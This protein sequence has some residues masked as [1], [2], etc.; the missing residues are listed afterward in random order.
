VVTPLLV[1]DGHHLL[2]RSWWGFSDRRITSRNKMR[3][4]TGV[5]GFL[6]ILRKTHL[7]EAP[8][9]E[10]IVVFDGEN[11]AAI[12]QTRDSGYK[13]NRAGV[14][15]TAIKSLGMIK[16]G[17]DATGVRWIELD[18][19]EGDDIVATIAHTAASAGRNVTC[20]SS[21]R[22]FY[23]LVNEHITLLT[24][25]RRRITPA[26]VSARHHITARQWPD[27]RALT[28]DSCDNIPG[29][30]GIGP[31]TAATL[32]A[33]GIHLEQLRNSSRLD[34]PRCRT[35]TQH[36]GQLLTW[37]D[38]IRLNR[39][40][41]LPSGIGTGQTTPTMPRAAEILDQLGLW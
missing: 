24:P 36:W 40:I 21:D 28:G 38:M 1:V 25:A 10:I 31:K 3:D 32:L 11:A 27:Y 30:R 5:F 16:D 35:V 41:P 22:D 7:E 29:I 12:R 8:D 37:H 20:Y 33:G 23:Q 9:H 39:T 13:N 18:T 2:Y 34:A 15:H 17:L 6:A 26:E 19:C 14:D 4:L